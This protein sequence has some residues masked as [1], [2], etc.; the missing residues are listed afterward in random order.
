MGV[1]PRSAHAVRYTNLIEIESH[2]IFDD[3][4]IEEVDRFDFT[5]RNNIIASLKDYG[6]RR[7]IIN[8]LKGIELFISHINSLGKGYKYSANTYNAMGISSPASNGDELAAAISIYALPYALPIFNSQKVD[9]FGIQFTLFW[10]NATMDDAG[11]SRPYYVWEL[12]SVVNNYRENLLV[13]DGQ[14]LRQCEHICHLEYLKHYLGFL[15]EYRKSKP[16]AKKK[17]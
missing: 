5:S 10:K 8:D 16:Q 11:R 14:K 9:G 7:F 1:S 2:R 13:V 15:K 3:D 12:F 4:N 17:C 6:V